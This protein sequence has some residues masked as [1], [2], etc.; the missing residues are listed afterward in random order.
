V[1][2]ELPPGEYAIVCTAEGQGEVVW[3]FGVEK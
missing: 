2:G 3:D 1:L